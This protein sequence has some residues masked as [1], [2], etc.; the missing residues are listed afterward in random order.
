MDFPNLSQGDD[1][2]NTRNLARVTLLTGVICAGVLSILGSAS[3]PS[4][5][6]TS[7][8]T[9]GSISVNYGFGAVSNPPYQCNGQVTVSVTAVSL[10]G[11]DG[12]TSA[13]A[14]TLTFS[15]FSSTTP[16]E[17]ACQKTAVFADLRPGTW[18]IKAGTAPP[19]QR[20]LAAGQFL[21]VRV[22]QNVCQ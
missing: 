10:T 19:C 16:N 14:Q 2:L 7:P 12:N 18:Q 20:T 8:P 21:N 4:G 13:P 15:D 22:W 17:P 1:I 9:K 11:S 6:P 5:G 3:G